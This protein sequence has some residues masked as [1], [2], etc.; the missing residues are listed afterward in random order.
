MSST[1][2]LMGLGMSGPLANLEGLTKT[3]LAGVGTSNVGA[4]KIASNF[5]ILTIVT[6]QT[7]VI[8]PA[9][10]T[11]TPGSSP[12]DFFIITN[13][14]AGADSA[15]IFPEAGGTINAGTATTGSLTL[16]QN[17][18]VMLIRTAPLKWVGILT[19]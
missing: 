18:T 3:T 15:L 12:G 11:V 9:T 5:V 16:A 19:A 8:L 10:G 1:A 2:D 17:K 4:A 13:P 7:A 14:A 6:G